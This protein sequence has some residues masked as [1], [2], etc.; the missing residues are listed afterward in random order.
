M[1]LR[2]H[3]GLFN[4]EH[5]AI[6]KPIIKMS[7][8][9]LVLYHSCVSITV[10]EEEEQKNKCVLVPPPSTRGRIVWV[11]SLPITFTLSLFIPDFRIQGCWRHL[12]IVTFLSSAVVLAVL[13]WLMM[14]MIAVVG[15]IP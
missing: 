5:V 15:E 6:L 12:Y 4:T 1:K 7:F 8:T 9:C 14:W 3:L 11:V 2:R 10:A 13:S